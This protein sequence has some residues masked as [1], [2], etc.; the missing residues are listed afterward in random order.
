[1]D[2]PTDPP[3]ASDLPPERGPAWSMERACEWRDAD[4]DPVTRAEMAAAIERADPDE[5]AAL[6]VPGLEFG[7]A[8]IRGPVG[9]G[10]NR[11]N[12]LLVRQTAAG[13]ARVLLRQDPP[14]LR[15]VGVV[16]GRDA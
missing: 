10:P 8:G 1:M 14:G 4:P 13:L 3:P 12:R 7:T 16:V 2:E 15:S 6:M 9:A 5:L 11:M